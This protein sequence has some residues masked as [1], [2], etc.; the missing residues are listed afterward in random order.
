MKKKQNSAAVNAVKKA[1]SINKL[2]EA[3]GVT[4][5]AV[6]GWL[7]NGINDVSRVK[8]VSEVT[9]IPVEEFL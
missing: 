6:Q 4:R 1:G 9:G 7:I 3:C 8:Q 2:A 5:Q